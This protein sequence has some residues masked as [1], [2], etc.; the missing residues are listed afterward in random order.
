MSFLSGNRDIAKMTYSEIYSTLNEEQKSALEL[1]TSGENVFITGNAGTG[2]SY[3]V[4]AFDK[5]CEQ[6]QLALMKT[7]PTGIASLEIGGT[8][9]HSQFNLKVGLD[10]EKVTTAPECLNK[11]DCLLVDEISMVRIDIFDKLME[12]VSLSNRKRKKPIQLVFVGD[13]YQLA[14]VVISEERPFLN[15]HYGKD[16]KDGYCF[17]SQYWKQNNIRLCNL[18]IVMRQESAEFCSALD[19]C[20]KGDTS[21]LPYIREHSSKN[22]MQNAIWVCGRNKTVNERNESELAKLSGR[23]YLSDAE[24]E[25]KATKSDKLCDE[26]FQFKIGARVVMLTNDTEQFL[27]Q[28]GTLG[29]ILRVQKSSIYVQI[30]GG[31]LVEVNRISI[32]KYEYVVSKGGKL[33]RIKIGAARQYPMRLGYAVTVHKS[34]GQ[35]YKKMNLEPEIF[36]NGQLYVALSRCKC[37]EN[38]YI[39][40]YLSNRMVMASEE[41]NS[42]FDNYDTYSFF[43][44]EDIQAVNNNDNH[45]DNEPMVTI[46]IPQKYHASVMEYLETLKKR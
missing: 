44:S 38:I 30:D 35:T 17:Q 15:N 11:V 37:I 10:F 34:Q 31:E 19:K 27:Y 12:I 4:K 39:H 18:T 7:A 28:N 3:L 16:I 5:Y 43:S 40:G 23:A 41:V 2:K 14:P 25:G 36:S 13:F 20:K 42:F 24:Y 26:Q 6:E 45:S 33:E 9:L 29:T 1:L 21:C 8:T 32:P 46:T 22:E